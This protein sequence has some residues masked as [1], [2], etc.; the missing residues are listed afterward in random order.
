MQSKVRYLE[1]DFV[2]V[3]KEDASFNKKKGISEKKISE[4]FGVPMPELQSGFEK[5]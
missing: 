1:I 4:R 5:F 2:L 3:V